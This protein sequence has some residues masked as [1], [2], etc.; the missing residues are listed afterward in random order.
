MKGMGR[1]PVSL[2]VTSGRVPAASERL[3]DMGE[4]N[5]TQ[6]GIMMSMA[7]RETRQLS[8]FIQEG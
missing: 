4:D 1:G 5:R 7:H 6:I 2:A 3:G 8:V